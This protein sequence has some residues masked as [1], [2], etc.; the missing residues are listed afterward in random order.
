VKTFDDYRAASEDDRNLDERLRA[1]MIDD[2]PDV[3]KLLA[4]VRREMQPVVPPRRLRLPSS[5]FMLR[6]VAAALFL[7]IITG[8]VMIQTR[9][10]TALAV[11]AAC[12]HF[13][14]L[15]QVSDKKWATAPADVDAYVHRN[16]PNR[17]DIV[18][19]LTPAGAEFE[20][21][22]SCRLLSARFAHFVYRANG[23]EVSVFVR[24]SE[25]YNHPVRPVDYTDT[26]L[27]L[28][29][30][31]FITPRYEGLVV[32]TVSAVATRD[33]ADTLAARL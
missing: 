9:R 7:T 27:R 32:A 11:D 17:L 28:Q 20:K 24:I 8:A 19:V 33:I 26:R 5:V 29:V 21:L 10:N 3:T 1:A 2:A 23:A 25:P 15:V 30:A 16:F 31:S 18:S 4:N 6:A 22:A 12:D 14:E 13:D